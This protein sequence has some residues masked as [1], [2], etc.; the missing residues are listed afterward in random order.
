MFPLTF[1]TYSKSGA[2][3]PQQA[4]PQHT[5]FI[6][7]AS[8]GIGRRVTERLLERG[9]RVAA[10][11]RRPE[12][13][14]DLGEKFR[15]QLWT[16]ALDVREPDQIRRVVDRCFFE[17][18]RVD[19]IFS[20]AGYGSVGAAEELSDDDIRGQIETNLL[21][22]IQ[23]TR[24][25]LPHL[26]AQRGGRILQ[27]TSMGGQIAMPGSAAYHAAKWGVEG[28]LEAVMGEVAAFGIGITLVEPGNVPTNFSASSLAV[29]PTL[30]AYAVG[31]AA[32]LKHLLTSP[33]ALDAIP[34]AD[35]DSVADAIIDCATTT[36]VRRRLTLGSDAY[37]AIHD[38]LTSRLAE[39]TD[40]RAL[41][42]STDRR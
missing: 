20:N 40:Q 14:A 7:G 32:Q 26:R 6:T 16:A 11:A 21:G 13:L 29:A 15:E 9:D 35:L 37:E 17:L 3:M 36:P 42:Q 28:F 34:A 22:P 8:S 4:V 39:L 5:W 19:V 1:H 41:A 33:G 12:I 2:T 31:P 30:P 27:V 25:V 10:T 24:A 23:L 38:A 18:G